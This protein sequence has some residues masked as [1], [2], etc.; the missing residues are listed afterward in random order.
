MTIGDATGNS[1]SG[2]GNLNE[3]V[4]LAVGASVVYTIHADVDPAAAGILQNLAE[5]QLT[6]QV[7]ANPGNN[8][9]LDVLP[10]VA[11]A[12]LSV[13]K[14]NGRQQVAIGDEVSYEIV[15]TNTGPSHV[16]QGR[17]VDIVPNGMENVQWTSPGTPPVDAVG[18]VDIN[19][20]L[21]AGAS[22]TYT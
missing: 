1:P 4:D 8:F 22:T 13:T 2:T 10:V 19:F 12:D 18:V 14:T 20:D 17:L 16:R 3:T 9:D 11:H 5:I 15:V 6:D 7:D 21:D